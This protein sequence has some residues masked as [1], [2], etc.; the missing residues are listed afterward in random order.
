[1]SKA[2]EKWIKEVAKIWPVAKGSIRE[3]KKTCSRKEC[4]ACASGKK[5]SAWL[6]TY[7]VNGK[8]SCKHVPKNKVDLVKQALDNGRKLD[9][10]ILESGLE[11]LSR[12]GD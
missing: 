9:L 11:L 4:K 7:Y 8:Q 2:Q 1:M 6:F 10:M 12:K 3:V 5:H